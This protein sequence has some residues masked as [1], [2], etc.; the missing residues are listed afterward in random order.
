MKG[1]FPSNI[2]KDDNQTSLEAYPHESSLEK[3]SHHLLISHSST[4]H[5]KIKKDSTKKKILIIYSLKA[6]ALMPWRHVWIRLR[7]REM[8]RIVLRAILPYPKV[9]KDNDNTLITQM[10]ISPNIYQLPNNQCQLIKLITF[11]A[12][13]W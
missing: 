2:F 8:Q 10:S 12:T 11:V 7:N 1:W 3:R 5:E 4:R 6:L 9:W 13:Q